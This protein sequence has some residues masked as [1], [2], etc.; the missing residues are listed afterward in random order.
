VRS[1]TEDFA[2]ETRKLKR[3]SERDRRARLEAEAIAERG[4]RELYEKKL[5][6]ELLGKIAVAANE[7][8]CVE[9]ALRFALANICQTTGWTLGHAYSVRSVADDIR[10][11]STRIWYG[12]ETESTRPF[13]IASEAIEFSPGIGLPGRVLST[14]KPSLILDLS[15]DTNFPRAEAARL[16]GIRAAFAFPVVAGSDVAAVLEFFADTAQAP[17]EFFLQLM[18]QIGTVLGRVVERS[19]LSRILDERNRNLQA[20]IVE[21]QHAEE[22]ADAANR[23]KSEF[24][25]NMS[26]EIRTPLNGVIGLTDI[27]LDT[28]LTS[29]QRECLETVKLSA[30][31]LLTL[32]NDILDFSKI[33]AGKIDLEAIDFN[34]RD[35]LEDALKMFALRATEK[36]LE[37]LCDLAPTLP[38]MVRGDSGRLRQIILNLVSNA[39]KFTNSGEVALKAELESRER[40]ELTI[41]FTVSDT[42]IGIPQEKQASIFS[43]FTQA[44]SST[45]RKYGGTGLGLTISTRLASMMGGGIWVES[46]IGRGSRFCF[47]ARMTAVAKA[48]E[49]ATVAVFESLRDVRILVVDDNQTNRQIL[50]RTLDTWNARTTCVAGGRQALLE[51]AS[52]LEAEKPYQVLVTDK[53]MPDMDGFDLVTRIRGLPAMASVPVLML[54]SGAR[55][56]DAEL[57]RQLGITA[58]LSK[59]VRRKELLSAI[60]ALLRCQTTSS[61]SHEVLLPTVTSRRELR[62]LLAEDN[63]VNQLVASRLL[64]KLGHVFVIANNGQEAIELLQQQA[65]DLVLMDVQMPEMDGILATKLIREHEKSTHDHIPIIAM[66]AHAMIGDRARCIAA[67][68]D[69]YVTKPINLEDVEA[70]ILTALDGTPEGHHDTSVDNHEGKIM[71]ASGP[72]WNMTKTLEQLGGDEMLLH[73]VMDI[74]LEEAPKHLATLRLAVAQGVAETVETAAHTLKGELGYLGIPEISQ[75]ASQIEE[76]GRCNNVSGAATLLP[77]FEA[78]VSGLFTAIRSAKVLSWNRP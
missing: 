4:F 35:C 51:L 48:M 59:P 25:A 5:Q 64:A 58:F 63:S 26:H 77:Q 69:G 41:R 11:I 33:E 49:S 60:L 45:T 30:D 57:C 3:R 47:S 2:E 12:S 10:L 20:E 75:R 71:E 9:D 74:F 15:Q 62:I 1:A 29:D 78:D 36:G 8:T 39:I 61:S 6:I 19:R 50:Q 55:I 23:A 24:L 16:A 66:T 37:L 42:G 54:S 34:L 43:P 70:A 67:G 52:A 14:G 32:V 46:E 56:E 76:M 31:S 17:D 13:H 38:E 22:A 27:V 53:H 68:M 44:D 40:D 21:R 65:F 73:E 7:S 72:L 28:D 18:A